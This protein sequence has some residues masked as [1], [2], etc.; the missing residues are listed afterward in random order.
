MSFA[1][2]KIWSPENDRVEFQNGRTDKNGRFSFF[3]D[4]DG[5]W[6]ITVNDGMGHVATLKPELSNNVDGTI[7][8]GGEAGR[9]E[10]RN[11]MLYACLGCSL[12][13]NAGFVIGRFKEV[14][15]HRPH[16]VS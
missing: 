13:F 5:V 16:T 11:S 14:L 9:A 7:G 12:I 2:V 15:G 4:V 8:Y 3:P 1:K 6:H 10:G